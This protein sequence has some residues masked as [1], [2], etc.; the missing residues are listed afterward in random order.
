MTDPKARYLRVKQEQHRATVSDRPSDEIREEWRVAIAQ[1]M[2]N[3]RGAR[4]LSRE[5][6]P[7][8]RLE[9]ERHVEA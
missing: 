8:D 7:K 9:P 2:D 4:A 5:G 1:A 3:F 6:N